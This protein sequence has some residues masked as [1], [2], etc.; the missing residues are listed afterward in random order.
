MT[1]QSVTGSFNKSLPIVAAALARACGVTI[2]MGALP[3]TDGR[4]IRLP[5]TVD[6]SKDK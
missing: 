3:S 1:T 6:R 5:M 2:E 4:M